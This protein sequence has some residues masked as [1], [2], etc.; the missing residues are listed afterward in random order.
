MSIDVIPFAEAHIPAAAALV[1]ARYRDLHNLVPLLP[2]SYGDPGV[3]AGLLG[4]LV[5]RV[6]GAAAIRDGRLAGFLAGYLI[7]H[8]HARPGVFC[9]EWAN[10]VEPDDGR[11]L[12]EALYTWLAPRWLAGGYIQHALTLFAHDR[13]AIE[14]W[15]WLGF[16]LAAADGVRSLHPV[17]VDAPGVTVRRAALDDVD[18]VAALLAGLR[19]H[20]ASSPTFL[21]QDQ[22]DVHT[23]SEA[24]LA[25]PDITLWLAHRDSTPVGFLV[26]GP[27]SDNAS[28]IIVDPGTCSITGAYTLPEARG[29]DVG[30]ALLDRALAWARDAGYTRCAVDFE[31]MNVL[32]AR[33][34]TRHFQITSL[35][36]FRHV[37]ERAAGGSE[38]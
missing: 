4:R 27:A 19:R 11:R 8:F 34:W 7:P 16:G 13:P 37:D 26:S 33:F 12:Y 22:E 5:P 24:W 31:P 9:P 10:A 23:Q 30:T 15:H 25:D 3:M 2:P 29:R 20:L 14:A 21:I 38:T 18:A 17:P 1:A 6:P 35:S 28:T 36:L 32:A